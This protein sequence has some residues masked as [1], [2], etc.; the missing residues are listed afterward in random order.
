MKKIIT[1]TQLA[2]ILANIRGATPAQLL[3]VT[4]PVKK[5]CPFA[6]QKIVQSN[7]MLNCFYEAGV[8]R[9]LEK[10]GKPAGFEAKP[11]AWGSHVMDG[12]RLTPLVEH[13]GKLYMVCQFNRV[14]SVEYRRDGQQVDKA[15]L[16]DYLPKDRVEGENQGLDK[17]L[18]VRTYGLDSIRSIT[19]DRE[20]F[21]VV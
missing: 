19:I 10:E 7:V 8:N 2:G 16:A 5:V 13:K 4:N 15:G 3:T 21:E 14:D 1:Q 20:T 11:R 17:A 9:R 6:V 12:D 18:V